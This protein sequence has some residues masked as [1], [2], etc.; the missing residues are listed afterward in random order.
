MLFTNKYFQKQKKVIL[1]HKLLREVK[2]LIKFK[3]L[4]RLAKIKK[5]L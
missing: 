4:L 2:Q 3:D 1:I 5:G